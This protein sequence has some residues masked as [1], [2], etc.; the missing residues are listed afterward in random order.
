MNVFGAEVARVM[1][2]AAARGEVADLVR[3]RKGWKYI[4]VSEWRGDC[5]DGNKVP[6]ERSR[7]WFAPF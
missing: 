4:L 5:E 2:S 3:A 7:L 1:R 6:L